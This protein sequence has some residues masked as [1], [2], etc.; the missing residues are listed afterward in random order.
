[1]TLDPD[2]AKLEE[3]SDTRRSVMWSIGIALFAAAIGWASYLT[4]ATNDTV[5][6][7]RS[8]QTDTHSVLLDTKTEVQSIN[9]AIKSVN[10]L[11]S[12]IQQEGAVIVQNQRAICSDFPGCKLPAQPTINP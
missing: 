4:V 7:I 11:F 10:R 3:R 5:G 9:N 2:K 12:E 8:T 1:V 6:S